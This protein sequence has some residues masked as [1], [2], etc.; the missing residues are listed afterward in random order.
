MNKCSWYQKTYKKSKRQLLVNGKAPHL[1]NMASILQEPY[2]SGHLS[3][4]YHLSSLGSL[5][6]KLHTKS[7]LE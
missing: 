1:N 2:Q 4:K 6:L 5:C 7:A 3:I